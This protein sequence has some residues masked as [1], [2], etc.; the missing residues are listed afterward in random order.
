MD[1]QVAFNIAFLIAGSAIGLWVKS[2]SDKNV[3]RKT[4]NDRTAH[5][6]RNL[7]QTVTNM[8]EQIPQRYATID[9]LNTTTER[10]E[11]TTRE[12]GERQDKTNER[13]F[14]ALE[15]IETKIDKATQ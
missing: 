11:R 6:L 5:D 7:T 9:D 2:V 8:R 3:D 12:A 4:D 13:I 1:Y 15:R 10:F 14:S